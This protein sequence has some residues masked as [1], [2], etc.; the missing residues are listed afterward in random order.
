ME[1]LA[2]ALTEMRPRPRALATV[3]I[4]NLRAAALFAL[5]LLSVAP[6]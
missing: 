6:C 2:L 5:S 4:M 1:Q 3:A